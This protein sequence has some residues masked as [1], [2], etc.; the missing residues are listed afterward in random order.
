MNSFQFLGKQFQFSL[1][2]I[3]SFCLFFNVFQS[4]IVPFTKP[5]KNLKNLEIIMS[6]GFC[7]GAP[8]AKACFKNLLEKS[9]KTATFENFNGSFAFFKDFLKNFRILYAK[10]GKI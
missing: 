7:Y 1:I 8:E 10:L 4:L 6:V 3:E 9:M 5:W 2:L